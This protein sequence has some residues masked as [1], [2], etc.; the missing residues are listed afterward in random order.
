ME[1]VVVIVGLVGGFVAMMLGQPTKMLVE[2]ATPIATINLES[3]LPLLVGASQDQ[4][5]VALY[6]LQ[7]HL[8]GT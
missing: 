4:S 3:S 8:L 2:I 7:T 6:V 1:V 5:L